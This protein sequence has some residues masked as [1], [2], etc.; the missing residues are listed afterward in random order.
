[1]GDNPFFDQLVVDRIVDIIGA[2]GFLQV[3]PELYVDNNILLVGSFLGVDTH[4]TTEAQ[5][6]DVDSV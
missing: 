4:D 5:V 3:H 6:A 1:M 2:A